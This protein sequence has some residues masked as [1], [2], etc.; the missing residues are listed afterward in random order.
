MFRKL[1]RQQFDGYTSHT[2]CLNYDAAQPNHESKYS[3]KQSVFEIK[4][5][6]CQNLKR[7][8]TDALAFRWHIKSRS[9]SLHLNFNLLLNHV[10]FQS[11][12]SSTTENGLPASD[13][14]TNGANVMI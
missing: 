13:I 2:F 3:S 10:S 12:L 5:F 9:A 8:Y 1:D 6:E 7:L 11:E 14:L 4:R